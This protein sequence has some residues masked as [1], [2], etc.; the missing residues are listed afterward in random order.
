MCCLLLGLEYLHVNNVIH[1]DIKPENLV[2][3]EKGY[4]R[5]TDFGIAKVYK[6]ENANETSGTPGYMS[7]EVLLGK[8]HG[9]VVDYFALGVITYEFM[10]GKRPYNGKRREIK[11]KIIQKQEKVKKEEIPCGWSIEAADFVNR[12][13]QRKA[14]NRLGLRGAL[15]VREHSWLKYYHWKDL[16][17]KRIIAPFQPGNGDNFDAKYCNVENKIGADT[18]ARYDVIGKDLHYKDAFAHFTFYGVYAKELC[19]KYAKQ[20]NE[21]RKYNDSD[22]GILHEFINPHKNIV[23]Y[24]EKK[25][26]ENVLMNVGKKFDMNN[27]GKGDVGG[28]VLNNVIGDAPMFNNSAEIKQTATY[29]IDFSMLNDDCNNNNGN[30]DG[31]NNNINNISHNNISNNINN[32]IV[33][34]NNS[35]FQEKQNQLEH[36]FLRIKQQSI[37]SSSTA[38]SRAYRKSNTNQSSLIGCIEPLPQ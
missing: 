7:P 20:G 16:Y 8:N 28:S 27:N 4:L 9:C 15:E 21:V 6:R 23:N 31:S 10:L 35:I 25:R 26:E 2:L 14:G 1:R 11:E 36:K 3:D 19:K 37:S 17:D 22:N 12:L 38:L 24:L 30:V 33:Y 18:K 32:D 5:I 29:G 34:I 13:L